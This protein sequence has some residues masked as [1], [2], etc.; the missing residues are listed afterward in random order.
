MTR[1][2]ATRLTT[3][4][5]LPMTDWTC[6]FS[7]ARLARGALIRTA[8]FLAS[9]SC[10]DLVRFTIASAPGT[11]SAVGPPNGTCS[12]IAAETGYD[13]PAV[14]CSLRAAA[15]VL[16]SRPW[17]RFDQTAA[18]AAVASGVQG[19][20]ACGDTPSTSALCPLTVIFPPSTGSTAT[21]PLSF[22]ILATWAEL[23]PPGTAAIR[24]GTNCCRG[25]VPPGPEDPVIGPKPEEAWEDGVP[26]AGAATAAS[27]AW[28]AVPATLTDIAA[29][30][31]AARAT[32]RRGK[33]STMYM[34]I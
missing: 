29:T 7:A 16:M 26:P 10:A 20:K 6:V 8:K 30:A 18:E 19:R 14:R 25:T 13:F 2:Y 33:G 9:P 21:T 12:P 11:L 15:S 1:E 5:P 23:M 4:P 22:L 34:T 24:S 32:R 28:T 3:W 17:L 27:A 31:A